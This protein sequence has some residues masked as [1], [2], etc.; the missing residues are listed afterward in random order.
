[1]KLSFDRFSLKCLTRMIKSSDPIIRMYSDIDADE[2]ERLASIIE[3]GIDNH[4]KF[5]L[6]SDDFVE[7]TVNDINFLIDL[8]S[9]HLTTFIVSGGYNKYKILV[10]KLENLRNIIIGD[11][12]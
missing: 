8:L 4:N 3:T 11:K 1:M 6:I 9:I 5:Y 2:W 12:E 10:K 7:I